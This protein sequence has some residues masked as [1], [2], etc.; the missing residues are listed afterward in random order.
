LNFIIV[1]LT[2]SSNDDRADR[3]VGVVALAEAK[4]V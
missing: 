4:M 3:H 1:P 2:S